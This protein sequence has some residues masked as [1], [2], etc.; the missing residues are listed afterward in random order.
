MTEWHE[1]K[2]NRPENKDMINHKCEGKVVSRNKKIT[3]IKCRHCGKIKE[4]R[5]V[6]KGER[7]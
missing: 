5:T 3:T 4:L 2:T 6:T 1:Y 7:K